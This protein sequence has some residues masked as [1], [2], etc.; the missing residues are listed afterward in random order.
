MNA[1]ELTNLVCTGSLG[2]LKAYLDSKSASLEE[3]R[4]AAKNKDATMEPCLREQISALQHALM[5]ACDLEHEDGYPAAQNRARV[6]LLLDGKANVGDADRTDTTWSSESAMVQQ[7]VLSTVKCGH[8]ECLQLL[9]DHNADINAGLSQAYVDS[10]LQVACRDGDL[11][12]VQ[13]LL[14]KKADVN[15][16]I[17]EKNGKTRGPSVKAARCGERKGLLAMLLSRKDKYYGEM[18]KEHFDDMMFLLLC[19]N[20]TVED[21]QHSL[22][23]KIFIDHYRLYNDLIAQYHYKLHSTLYGEAPT[24]RRVGRRS[25]GIYQEPLERVLEYLGLSNKAVVLN[26]ALDKKTAKCYLHPQLRGA[27]AWRHFLAPKKSPKVRPKIKSRVFASRSNDDEGKERVKGKAR[28]VVIANRSPST[29]TLTPP[30]APSMAADPFPMNASLSLSPATPV[31][32]ERKDS[33]TP[34]MFSIGSSGKKK[35]KRR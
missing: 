25:N 17:H 28:V 16:T 9:L 26:E 22:D 13:F 23:A 2:A 35:K 19:G 33:A 4:F 20:A 7:C 27:V 30:L 18:Q 10:T 14:E 31:K 11:D 1:S 15:R 32:S 3:A 6:K 5:T 34:P 24:D 8:K 12:F 29:K 21:V